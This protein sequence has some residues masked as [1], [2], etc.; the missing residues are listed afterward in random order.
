MVQNIEWV[1]HDQANQRKMINKS[2]SLTCAKNAMYQYGHLGSMTAMSNGEMAD[3]PEEARTTHMT[4]MRL[5]KYPVET[6]VMTAMTRAGR[7]RTEA[8]SAE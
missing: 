1:L 4:G 2:I 3:R 8:S 5:T 6:L 7:M